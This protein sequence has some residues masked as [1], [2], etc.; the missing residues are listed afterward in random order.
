MLLSAYEQGIFPWYSEGEPIL[1]HSPDP[2]FVVFPE[3]LHI[4]ESMRKVLRHRTFDLRLDNDFEAVIRAC[5]E[6]KRP[7]Q[8]GTWITEDMMAAYIELHRLGWVH[9][10]EAYHEGRLVGGCYGI[11]LGNAFFGE[12]MFAK[13][14]N[15]SKAA[16]LG[17]AELLFSDGVG[18]IDCQ[19]HT[20]HLE[21]LGAVDVPRNRFIV[22]LEAALANRK[23]FP[24]ADASYAETDEADRR[25]NWGKRYPDFGIRFSVD[26]ARLCSLTPSR[27][28]FSSIP[29]PE[30]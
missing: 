20:D 4:S 22:F 9:S 5:S 13:E 16:F 14:S 28:G 30:V 8:N 19:V 12:S 21:S 24:D 6:A 18:F 27:K 10:S 25:G 7:G 17:I 29:H 1:W 15:S 26:S 23:G 3:K 11:R 2:R